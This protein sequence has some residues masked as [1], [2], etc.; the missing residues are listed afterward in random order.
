MEEKEAVLHAS[1]EHNADIRPYKEA[2]AA[3]EPSIDF[4]KAVE[5]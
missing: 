2:R 1:D 5:P 4:Q 3:D